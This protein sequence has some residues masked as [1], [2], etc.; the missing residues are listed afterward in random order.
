MTTD[1]IPIDFQSDRIL[2]VERDGEPFVPVRPIC[3]NLGL[4]WKTQYR[5]LMTTEGRWGVVIMT[6]PSAGGPQEMTCIPLTRLFGWLMS[7]HPTK[8]RP[9]LAD[10][11]IAYQRECDSVLW[12]HFTGKATAREEALATEVALLRRFVRHLRAQ[13]LVAKPLWNRVMR[14]HE[15]GYGWNSIRVQLG[16]SLGEWQEVEEAMEN[17]G[18]LPSPL[19]VPNR[20][21]DRALAEARHERDSAL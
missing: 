4:D 9:D 10:K 7:I 11:L 20:Q 2:L 16:R 1:L 5:K 18:L 8:V 13:V 14:L 21:T 3:E 12:A 6:T 19:G 15:V 17:C